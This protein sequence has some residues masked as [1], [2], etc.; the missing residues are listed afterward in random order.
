MTPKT[1]LQRTIDR[2]LDD[3]SKRGQSGNYR[4][5]ANR[6][7]RDWHEW[8]ANGQPSYEQRTLPDSYTD[9]QDTDSP[10]RVQ[11][12]TVE[13]FAD[14]A[15]VLRDKSYDD[16]VQFSA[17]TA[18]TYYAYLRAFATWAVKNEL[19]DENPA[20]KARATDRLPDTENAGSRQQ[21]WTSDQREAIL[22]H[23]EERA[24]AAISNDPQSR[25]ALLAA[26]D[27]ALVALFA[28]SGL[29]GGEFL[30]DPHDDRRSGATWADLRWPRSSTPDDN[31]TTSIRVAGHDEVGTLEVLGKSQDR[32]PAPIL[33]P[34]FPALR[35]YYRLLA[36]ETEN[37]PI[38]PTFHAPT[39]RDAL[40]AAGVDTAATE[41]HPLSACRSH[42]VVPPAA[43]TEAGRHIMRRLCDEAEI[44]LPDGVSYLE[45]HGGRRGL[46]DILYQ[47]AP[48][49]A[50]DVLRHENIETTNRAYRERKVEEDAAQASRLLTDDS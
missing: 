7:L 49:L 34:A 44:T 2:F 33:E 27:R 6:V 23:V 31:A 38:F 13:H 10:P 46:G 1:A 30:R 50:Q 45:P 16:D 40:K 35:A 29:R 15:R 11:E 5:N 19:L 4:R 17:Q 14:Y 20:R 18:H 12:L 9:G 41:G 47:E 43:T 28:F 25:D 21:M 32:E 36:P 26:R 8:L 48:R 37:W 22:Q 3:K 39:L 24:N 42:D